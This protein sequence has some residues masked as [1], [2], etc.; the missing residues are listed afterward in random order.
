MCGKEED[1]AGTGPVVSTR[2]RPCGDPNCP[3]CRRPVPPPPDRHDTLAELLIAAAGLILLAIAAF[4]V[5]PIL[6]S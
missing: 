3:I 1:G 5:L 6:A 4:V 2:L